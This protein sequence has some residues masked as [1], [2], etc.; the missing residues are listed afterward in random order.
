VLSVTVEGYL[1][2]ALYVLGAGQAWVFLRRSNYSRITRGL[3]MIGWP[4]MAIAVMVNSISDDLPN[5]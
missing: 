5:A 3:V 1:A 4:I 2:G